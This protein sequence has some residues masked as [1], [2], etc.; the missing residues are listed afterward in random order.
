[1]SLARVPHEGPTSWKCGRCR[2]S[3]PVW[4]GGFCSHVVHGQRSPGCPNCGACVC[5]AKLHYQTGP[6]AA[7]PAAAKPAEGAP[8]VLVVDD[9]PSASD[10]VVA[11]LRS[12]GIPSIVAQ[13]GLSAWRILQSHRIAAV[14]TDV[15][16]PGLDGWQLCR[17]IKSAPRLKSMP[18][19]FSSG[20]YS[21]EEKEALARF[22]AAGFLRKP[23][24]AAKLLA[25]LT[26]SIQRAA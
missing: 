13:D 1:M 17:L 16:L 12:A 24:D 15:L 21:V 19:I 2:R 8:A 20:I 9:Q 25:A 18:V 22:G 26:R 6:G 5:E 4:S 3:Y 7:Q 11:V 23:V 14:V 10:R